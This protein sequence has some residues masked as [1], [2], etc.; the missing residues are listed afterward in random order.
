[1]ER[2]RKGIDL[3]VNAATV[4]V[5][6]FLVLHPESVIRVAIA[7][8]QGERQSA[9]EVKAL[10]PELTGDGRAEGAAEATTI[11]EFAD[12]QCPACRLAFASVESL[13]QDHGVRVVY[14]HLPLV[15]IHPHADAAA[16]ASICAET[17]G[18][19]YAMHRFLF[20][21]ESWD[22][23][24]TVA[25]QEVAVQAGVPHPEELVLCMSGDP[26]RERL[27]VDVALASRLGLEG[28]P[29]FLVKGGRIILGAVSLD[30]LMEGLDM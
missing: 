6:A 25:W 20:T 19:F 22:S 1:M 26:A 17:Q 21:D 16:L 8:W 27:A 11:V 10:W 3:A 18:A 2:L 7:E 14:R 29:T 30:E 28:T 4:A 15:Q 9:A 23:E 13:A 5:I 24:S 12:Y